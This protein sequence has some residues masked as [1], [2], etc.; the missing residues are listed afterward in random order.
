MIRN[1]YIKR[2]EQRLADL[3]EEID[4]LRRRAETATLDTGDTIRRQVVELR[5]N[6]EVA[7]RMIR[8]VRAAG[9]TNWGKLKAG[10]D[11]SLDELRKG[12]D[13]AL[14]R[15]RKTGADKR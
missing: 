10:V 5:T 3:G 7:R 15:I 14:I 11:G 8:D 1:A 4:S 12:I 6:V 2:A 13:N 9:A